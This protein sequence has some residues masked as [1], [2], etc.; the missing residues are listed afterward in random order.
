MSNE[1]SEYKSGLDTA[2]GGR[3]ATEFDETF[4]LHCEQ[5]I[6][7]GREFCDEDCEQA[8]YAQRRAQ[9]KLRGSRP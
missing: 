7:H 5:E 2:H 9:R 6:P 4:C 8:Y 1:D 3:L